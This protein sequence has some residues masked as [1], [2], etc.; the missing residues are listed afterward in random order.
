MTFQANGVE[1]RG[2]QRFNADGS[3]AC[4]MVYN[5]ADGSQEQTT[6]EGT[7]I[8]RG[9]WFEFHTDAGDYNQRYRWANGGM[10][11]EFPDLNGWIRFAP[12]N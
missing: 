8:D 1:I 9:T 7:W 2:I 5:Y 6:E 11:M 4:V 12:V 3:Y 10:E